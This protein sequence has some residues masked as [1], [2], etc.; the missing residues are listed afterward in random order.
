MHL[1]E[2]LKQRLDYSAKAN[3]VVELPMC[4]K[5]PCVIAPLQISEDLD[6]ISAEEQGHFHRRDQMMK[7]MSKPPVG[8]VLVEDLFIKAKE[9][10]ERS[11]S[12]QHFLTEE[13]KQEYVLTHS[14][15]IGIIGQAGSGKTTLTKTILN[16]VVNGGL[17]S[18]KFVFY[19]KL[20]DVDYSAK[21]NLLSFL[22]PS[23]ALPWLN[24]NQ[25][26][27][28][29]LNSLAANKNVFIIFDGLDEIENFSDA[30]TNHEI[31]LYKQDKPLVFIKHLLRGKLLPY[32]NVMITSRPKQ[33][34]NLP[35][36]L[37]PRFVV[38]IVGLD[39]KA[40]EKICKS[41]CEQN[42][43]DIFQ[44]IQSR[45]DIS[46]LCANPLHCL[47]IMFAMNT[48]RS[49]QQKF[50][51]SLSAIFALN[52]VLF[53]GSSHIDN[54]FN[55]RNVAD[56]A[57]ISFQE[58]KFYLTKRDLRRARIQ[59][60]KRNAFL[61]STTLKSGV[62][63]LSGSSNVH[64]FSHLVLQ[65]C[66]IAIRVIFFTPPSE[67]KELFI[68]DASPQHLTNS[69][70]KYNLA[71]SRFEMITKFMYGFCNEHTRSYLMEEFDLPDFPSEHL[72][73]LQSFAQNHLPS[74]NSFSYFQD[75][76]SVFTWVSELDN[77]VFS[78]QLASH[79]PSHIRIKGR[80]LPSDVEP[81]H[82]ILRARR[83]PVSLSVPYNG[84]EFVGNS[85]RVF[86]RELET[87]MNNSRYVKVILT[88]LRF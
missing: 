33:L 14:R 1:G 23:L 76:L 39:D 51:K 3:C 7:M 19:V 83:S 88:F 34:L 15:R 45:A 43:D 59:V 30:S 10:V 26:R 50:L 80:V 12:D 75:S 13:A 55:L 49:S 70:P 8:N 48:A 82:H 79:L 71:D 78:E 86:L 28:A 42:S 68:G 73:M 36:Y 58:N 27:N 22:S 61:T 41:V 25:R 20:R 16:K 32:A 24:N 46:T 5:G 66:L 67:F 54:S 21:T 44:S 31:N 47:L 72:E 84:V 18:S 77:P 6:P 56:L 74:P 9:S 17:Y 87:T 85:Y 11:A 64:Y 37:K 65:E 60:D 62:S 52:L 63:L 81:V 38:N 53:F 40:Q 35:K 57:W 69:Q 29:V 2:E 4:L